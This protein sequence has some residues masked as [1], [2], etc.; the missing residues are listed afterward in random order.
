MKNAMQA[1]NIDVPLNGELLD[2]VMR[3]KAARAER[4][5]E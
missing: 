4:A 1:A 2:S 5:Q 3:L